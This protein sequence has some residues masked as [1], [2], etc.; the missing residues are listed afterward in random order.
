MRRQS[1][2]LPSTP[3]STSNEKV[4]LAPPF[5]FLDMMLLGDR[6]CLLPAIDSP[7]AEVAD[8]KSNNEADKADNRVIGS[9]HRARAPSIEAIT[10]IDTLF[11]A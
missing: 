2:G 5:A 11:L 4:L 10:W 3:T 9:G 6:A 7:S 8:I 1:F